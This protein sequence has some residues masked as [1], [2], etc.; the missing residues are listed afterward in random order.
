MM[1]ELYPWLISFSLLYAGHKMWDY[2]L[3]LK[4]EGKGY[5]SLSYLHK[6]FAVSCGLYGFIILYGLVRP[7]LGGT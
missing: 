7:L 4:F 5:L 6:F 3:T 2:S 1:T